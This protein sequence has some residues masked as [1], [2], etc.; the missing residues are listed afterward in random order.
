M[1]DLAVFLFYM[2]LIFGIL[3]L[4]G[5]VADYVFPHIKPLERW[6]ESLPLYGDDADEE[7]TNDEH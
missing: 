1:Y 2:V 6:R 5:F 4:G 7:V 3:A